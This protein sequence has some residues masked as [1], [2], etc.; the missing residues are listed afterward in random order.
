MITQNEQALQARLMEAF[1]RMTNKDQL[2][3]VLFA[4]TS[5]RNNPA[6]RAPKLR[7]VVNDRTKI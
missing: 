5:A 1:H 3:M 6:K 4:E 2:V 7:L